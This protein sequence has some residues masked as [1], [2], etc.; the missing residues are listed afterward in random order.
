MKEG[1]SHAIGRKEG[2]WKRALRSKKGTCQEAAL[3]GKKKEDR[4]AQKPTRGCRYSMTRGLVSTFSGKGKRKKGKAFSG[5]P[6][7]SKKRFKE[8]NSLIYSFLTRRKK[9]KR[10]PCFFE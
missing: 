6:E 10:W 7:R 5:G 1:E 2:S 3:F 9:G 8:K 4:P